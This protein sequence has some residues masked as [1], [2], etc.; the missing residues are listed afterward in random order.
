MNEN[1]LTTHLFLSITLNKLEVSTEPSRSADKELS[2]ESGFPED[3]D[4]R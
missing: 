3:I 4:S 1:L 2:V